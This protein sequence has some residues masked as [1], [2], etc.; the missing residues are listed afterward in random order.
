[1]K[2]NV[3]MAPVLMHTSVEAENGFMGGS[4]FDPEAEHDEGVTIEGHEIGNE[5]N[6]FDN[7]LGEEWNSWDN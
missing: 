2:K 3:Y 7:P 6:Y 5:G 1:M 4:V